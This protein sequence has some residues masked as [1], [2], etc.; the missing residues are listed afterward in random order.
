MKGRRSNVSGGVRGWAVLILLPRSEI[1][2][3]CNLP[4]NEASV[5]FDRTNGVTVQTSE[6]GESA[7]GD[8]IAGF[9][10]SLARCSRKESA[11]EIATRSSTVGPKLWAGSSKVSELPERR[12]PGRGEGG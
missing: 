3:A 7:L 1:N 10:T 2:V 11:T 9:S 5:I 12:S 8:G 4:Y 6:V